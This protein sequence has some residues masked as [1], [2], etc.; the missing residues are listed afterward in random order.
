[1]TLAH[2][3]LIKYR[4]AIGTREVQSVHREMKISA[5]NIGKIENDVQIL[6]FSDGSKLR[7]LLHEDGQLAI[8]RKG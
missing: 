2:H 6:T 5:S 1:M 4:N 3:Y 8:A 7:T